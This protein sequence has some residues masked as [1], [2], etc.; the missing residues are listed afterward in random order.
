MKAKLSGHANRKKAE[1]KRANMQE[2]QALQHNALHA[3]FFGM[4][5]IPLREIRERLDP[6]LKTQAIREIMKLDLSNKGDDDDTAYN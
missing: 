3:Q 2:A 5:N 4:P 1:E 6:I